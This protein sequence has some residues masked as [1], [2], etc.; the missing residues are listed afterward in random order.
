MKM[1]DVLN[2]L[3]NSI[4]TEQVAHAYLFEGSENSDKLQAA[5]TFAYALLNTDTINHPNYNFLSVDGDTIKI[6]EHVQ[7]FFHDIILTSP[8]SE[9]KVYIINQAHKMNS[10]SQNSLL[11]TL[12]EPARGAIIILLTEN[13]GKLLPTVLS[14]VIRYTFEDQVDF[15]ASDEMAEQ[16][17]DV[18]NNIQSGSAVT[19]I[20]AINQLVSEKA[21]YNLWL[22]MM[23]MYYRNS[24]VGQYTSNETLINQPRTDK[25]SATGAALAIKIIDE[26]RFA[27][28]SNANPQIAMD[29]LVTKLNDLRTWIPPHAPV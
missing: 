6:R 26:I 13:S 15:K 1:L 22:D 16:F 10:A 14:R 21:N 25:I 20:S 23:Q 5:Q 17:I 3:L 24:L 12:E 11:K 29:V 18:M 7:P 8:Y 2:I 28:K 4:K 27:L 9:R 19:R